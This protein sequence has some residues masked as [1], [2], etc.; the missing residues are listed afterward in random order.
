LLHQPIYL[1]L[2][3]KL[4]PHSISCGK[5]NIIIL[6]INIGELPVS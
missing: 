2:P 5:E 6:L 1:F 3:N 4:C